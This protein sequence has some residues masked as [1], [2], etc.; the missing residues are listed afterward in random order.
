MRSVGWLGLACLFGLA[1]LGCTDSDANPPLEETT[2]SSVTTSAPKETK[3]EPEDSVTTDTTVAELTRE[4]VEA[5]I[6]AFLVDEVRV[7]WHEC[8]AVPQD[9]DAEEELSK[10]FAG[11]QLEVNLGLIDQLIAEGSEARPPSDPNHDRFDVEQ[12]DLAV[13]TDDSASVTYCIVDGW[14]AFLPGGAPDGSDAIINE[15]L[16]VQRVRAGLQRSESDGRWRQVWRESL[17]R[18]DGSDGCE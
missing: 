3:T 4:E 5:E 16:G 7:V 11:G 17:E 9:C 13:P 8:A 14:V 1:L 15:N 12:I 18:F 10:V 2:T 6:E